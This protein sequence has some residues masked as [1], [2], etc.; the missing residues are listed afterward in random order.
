MA[1]L[2]I[3][4]RE[5]NAR[6][7]RTYINII[8][9]LLLKGGSV[10][11]GFIL[12][13]LTLDY[14][15]PSEY[16]IWLTLSSIIGWINICDVGLGYGLRNKLTEALATNEYDKARIYISTSYLGLSSIM[17]VALFLA[18]IVNKFLNWYSILNVSPHVVANLTEIVAIIL[19]L[20]CFKLI[21]GLVGNIFMA[22]Q[23]SSAN[24]LIT[25]SGDLF[26]LIAIY[27][28]KCLIPGTLL[29]VSLILSS[30]TIITGAGISLWLF[31]KH[32]ELS[33]SIKHYKRHYFKDLISLGIKFFIIQIC[34][35][36]LF[37]SSNLIISNMFGP[38]DVTRYNVASKIFSIASMSF[39]IIMTP[40]WSAVTDAY[41]K[42]DF[43]WIKSQIR[44]LLSMW[45]IAC[46]GIVAICICAPY[47]YHFWIGDS[48]QIPMSLTIVCGIYASIATMS[49]IW[50]T[51]INGMGKT[52]LQLILGITSSILYIPT[53]IICGNKF[54]LTGIVIAL[55]FWMGF[56]S[57]FC[58]IQCHKLTNKTAKNVWNR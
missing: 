47:I 55:S 7:K 20:F 37:Q 32:P 58:A 41:V 25:F 50:T 45:T 53:A 40:Y 35:I 48:V 39:L 2:N 3:F 6:S 13:P 54:G 44:K 8:L 14:L 5:I 29:I 9:S 1:V 11:I 36:I 16:G 24:N 52:Y 27:T 43:T 15:S 19:T 46:L 51:F 12:V 28:C 42:Q 22:K 33:P 30:S 31:H 10:L 56:N 17:V 23:Q 18:L 4:K 49:S 38:E 26:A 21:V 57:I 34:G